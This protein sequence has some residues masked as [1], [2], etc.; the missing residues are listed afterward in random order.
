MIKWTGWSTLALAF[1]LSGCNCGGTAPVGADGGSMV[2][3]AQLSSLQVDPA[4]QTLA[5]SAGPAT[6]TYRTT[7]TFT[8]GHSEDVTALSNFHLEDTGLGSFQGAQFTS[9]ADR[10]GTTRVFAEAGTLKADTGLKLVLSRTA[11]DPDSTGLPKDPATL[12]NG[13]ADAARAPE[14]LYPNDGVLLPPNLGKLEIHFY[15]KAGNTLFEMSFTNALTAVKVYQR[16]AHPLNGGCIYL[17]DPSVWRWLAA[18]NRGGEALTLT[19]RGTDDAGT[20]VGTSE[21]VHFSFSLDDINGGLYYW[22]TSQGTG[23]MRFDFASTTQVSAEKFIGTELTSGTCVGCHSLSRDGRKIVA[24]AG[25]QN[26]GRVLLLD[27]AHKTPLVPFASSGKSVFESWNPDGSQYVGVYGDNNATDYGLMLFDGETG[28]KLGSI[29]GT[30]SSTQP[31]TH[32][33]WSGQGDS[34]AFTQVG[35]KGTNQRSFKGGISVVHRSGSSWDAP[36]VVVPAQS[37]KNH[38]YPAFSPDNAF[39]VYDESTCPTG[40]QHPHCNTDSDPSARLWAVVPQAGATPVDLA[41]ANAGGKLDQ[42]ST[43][44]SNSY[45]KWSPFVFRRN[46]ELGSQLQWLT[47]SS[48]RR[49]GLHD[50]VP[51]ASSSETTTGSL[52]WMSGIDPAKVAAGEDPSSPAFALPFQDITTSNHI[53]QWATEVVPPIF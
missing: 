30:G 14:L 6:L 19:V 28:A 40:D 1:A 52:L 8:D 21:P 20:A 37:G 25:G 42:G 26:D 32:P 16:C 51:T 50:L 45:P 44:L 24:E 38:Y 17:P 46:G 47:F 36:V 39:L 5:I 3:L 4:N 10:G 15:P 33:D 48:I 9:Q 29:A 53:A 11:I 13:P 31:A 27:V 49:Y 35:I 22:T 2:D 43:K 34:I 7:G 41:R 12:F 23:I 18:T